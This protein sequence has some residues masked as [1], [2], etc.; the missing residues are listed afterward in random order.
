GSGSNAH[1][2]EV[3]PRRLSRRPRRRSPLRDPLFVQALAPRGGGGGADRARAAAEGGLS[4]RAGGDSRLARLRGLPRGGGRVSRRRR[5]T[6]T[7]FP[8]RDLGSAD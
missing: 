7:P 6:R 2:R 8:L 3:R 1:L 5:P 4:G